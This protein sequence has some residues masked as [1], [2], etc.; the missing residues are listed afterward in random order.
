ME[1]LEFI[2]KMQIN[3]LKNVNLIHIIEPYLY[4]KVLENIKYYFVDEGFSDFNYVKLNFD[5]MTE[6]L[7]S[8]EIETLPFLSDKKIVIVENLEIDKD[9]LKK[10]EKFLEFIKNKI[11]NMNVHTFLFFSYA[12]ESLFK[13]KFVKDL[14]KTGDIIYLNRLD[15]IKLQGFIQK[16]FSKFDKNIKKNEIELIIEKSRYLEKDS[17]L[18]LFDVENEL[19][20]LLNHS[21]K[22]LITQKDIEDVM[23]DNFEEK[24]FTLI[25]KLSQKKM[26]EAFAVYQGI[27]SMDSRA[28]FF[29]IVRHIRN[30]ICVKD[31]VSKKIMKQTAVEYC[32]I[33]PFEYGKIESHID[34]FDMEK[35]LQLHNMCFKLEEKSKTV[36]ID[37]EMYLENIIIK[38][39]M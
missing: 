19:S 2:K 5:T 35:L 10:N 6:D 4:E 14:E 12:G 1:F 29:M 34:G 31:C 36:N 9:K 23:I 17:K 15:K 30:M 13:G 18:N 21:E 38:F 20:K 27:K 7:F 22:T 24:I 8:K 28:I 16:Y 37:F 3:Q 33:K 11:E 39:C 32:G 25:D 26:K